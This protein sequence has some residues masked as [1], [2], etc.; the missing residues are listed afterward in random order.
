M[1]YMILFNIYMFKIYVYSCVMFTADCAFV[2]LCTD[3][4][5]HIKIKKILYDC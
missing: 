3:S 1:Y 5:F 4:K 2:L